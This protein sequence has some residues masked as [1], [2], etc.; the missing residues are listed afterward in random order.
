[1]K[2]TTSYGIEKMY[3][4]ITS[5]VGYFRTLSVSILFTTE[6]YDD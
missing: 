3:L 5:P 1:M 2:K 4:H 6:W